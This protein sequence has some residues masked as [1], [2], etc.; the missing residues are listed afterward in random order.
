MKVTSALDFQTVMMVR[1]VLEFTLESVIMQKIRD[2]RVQ[3]ESFVLLKHFLV[4]ML[5]IMNFCSLRGHVSN[6][7]IYKYYTFLKF[8]YKP[9]LFYL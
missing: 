9:M 1:V 6:I 2:K 8:D 4:N 3:R 7:E 5:G